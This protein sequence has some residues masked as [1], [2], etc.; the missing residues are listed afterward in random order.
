MRIG[1]TFP[2]TEIGADPG[3]IREYAQAADQLGYTHLLAYDHVVGADVSNR[4]DW[5]GPYTSETM[6]HEP[7]VLFGFLAGI[8]RR[9]EFVTGI[10]I[11]PQRQTVLVAKQAAE[12][13]VLSGGRF[14]LGVG[15]GWNEVEYEALGE[16]F[17]NRARRSEEQ[18]ALLRQLFSERIVTFHGKYHTVEAAGIH[19]L[20]VQ[21]PLPIWLGG[22]SD[23]TLQRTA[24]LADGWFPQ[25]PPDDTA[26]EMVESLHRYAQEAGR[27]PQSI[28]VEARLNLGTTPEGEWEGFI[29]R[30]RALGATHL[31]INTMN[32]GLASPSE[33]IATIRR[34]AEKGIPLNG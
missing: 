3:A 32:A 4:P 1:V 9:L 29:E 30:W 28:G 33:H 15:I 5:R 20:P 8:T 13:D 6:F 14:R 11:L 2:Q 27:D 22:G 31:A 24:R 17:R 12:V 18:I 25:R 23:A 34:F 21:Q 26:R 16:N 19:P 10:V 7:F